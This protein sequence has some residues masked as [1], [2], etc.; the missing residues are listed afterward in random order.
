MS[1]LKV[2]NKY[3]TPGRSAEQR[4]MFSKNKPSM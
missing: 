3:P 4:I 1:K 2:D